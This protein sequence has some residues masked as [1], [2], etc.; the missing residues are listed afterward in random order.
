MD[1]T[2]AFIPPM[3]R[4]T[5]TALPSGF[6]DPPPRFV[7]AGSDG[8]LIRT[9]RWAAQRK[10]PRELLAYAAAAFYRATHPTAS[11]LPDDDVA[12]GNALADL[13]VTGRIAYTRF[14]AQHPI[15]AEVVTRMT[16]EVFDFMVDVIPAGAELSALT[17]L[18]TGTTPAQLAGAIG[19]ALDRAYDV[20]WALRGPLAQRAAA[21]APLG[22]IAVSGEDDV[23]H[24]PVNVPA[25]PFE[26]YELPVTVANRVGLA[27][28][29]VR[30]RFFIASTPGGVLPVPPHARHALP[31]DPLLS[32]PDGSNVILFL[33]GHSSSADEA[34][35]IIPHLHMAGLRLGKKFAIV[36][37]DLPNNGYA[38]RFDHETVAPTSATTWPDGLLDRDPISV[39]VLDH[40][41]DFVVAFVDAL[42]QA[43]PI[44][45]RFSG[46]IGG[47]LGGNLGLRLGRR[48]P[49][50]AWL[51]AGIVSWSAASVWSPMVND[52]ILSQA[53]GRCMNNWSAHEGPQSR[54]DYFHEVYEGPVLPPIVTTL[55]P[56]IAP[57]TQPDLWYRSGWE[58]C[59]RLHIAGSRLA[60][61]EIY[62][63]S[64]R[65]WHW[66]V[67]G[68]QL[69]FSHVDRTDHNDSSTSFRHEL[70]RVNQLL[71]AGESDNF[72]GTQIYDAT[73]WMAARMVNTQGRSLFLRET[74]HSVH[75]E[76]PAFLAKQIAGFLPAAPAILAEPVT[77]ATLQITGIFREQILSVGRVRR[78]PKLGRILLVGGIDHTHQV[79]FSMSVAECVG[80]IEHGSVVFVLRAD[81]TRTRVHVVKSGRA[82][83]YIATDHDTSDANNLY[84][85]P[86]LTG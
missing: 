10:D 26:Q 23:P 52:L 55:L 38:E 28:V 63:E 53:P 48:S 66:R 77:V 68:E 74:G 73:R 51:D 60:R 8:R 13:A 84:S 3:E 32:I 83:P 70:N 54:L 41:E 86:R 25:P 44:K 56:F 39:P 81:G 45:N 5:D 20:V 85:L 15:E 79:P 12:L 33:H 6:F 11:S 42:D 7:E 46:V 78:P 4:C 21:R 18:P 1:I 69:I 17:A 67:A 29:T 2:P 64:F 31:S 19:T 37:L 22:W 76:R 9:L 49:M 71:I 59:K 50:P 62:D 82:R 58:P 14:D 16:T 34:L 30:T 24:R 36:A 61:R 47:S 72:E 80:H 65:R 27:D 57:H 40:V 43:T 75:F 35:A